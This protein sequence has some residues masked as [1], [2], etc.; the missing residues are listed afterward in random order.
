MKLT[1][2]IFAS[3][4]VLGT[5]CDRPDF[6]SQAKT[7]DVIDTDVDR[8]TPTGS[9]DEAGA[10]TG[11]E[12]DDG[13]RFENLNNAQGAPP[14]EDADEAPARDGDL[15]AIVEAS[16]NLGFETYRARAGQ[17]GPIAIGSYGLTRS[18]SVASL[19]A[20]EP[21]RTELEARVSNGLVGEQLHDAFNTLDSDL[22]TR[23][24]ASRIDLVTATWVP[25]SAPVEQAFVDDLARYYG[26]GVRRAEFESRPEDARI[27]INNFYRD[28]T[29]GELTDVVPVRTVDAT[30]NV[31]ITDGNLFRGTFED[32]FD[33]AYTAATDFVG[34]SGTRSVP[35]MLR[36]GS[37]LGTTLDG[38]RAIEL[39]FDSG[40]SLLLI[41]PEA[42]R[43]DEIESRFDQTLVDRILSNLVPTY[44]VLG[45]PRVTIADRVDV[46]QRAGELG[47]DGAF[48][49]DFSGVYADA[50]LSNIVQRTRLQLVEDGVNA[51]PVGLAPL[52]ESEAA[53][54]DVPSI[55]FSRPF[56]YLVRDNETGTVLFL[57]RYE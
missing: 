42:G 10:P 20:S 39:P 13:G 2:A 1:H 40:F 45:V 57:G 43:F 22:T 33:P 28:R 21:A 36:E 35:M 27:S 38:L 9:G 23:D 3:L 4:L 15:A 30:T 46:L 24:G 41:L 7:G 31:L 53:A 55:F 14:V 47:L 34:P 5:A 18:A 29:G 54:A 26:Q 37:V 32:A 51:D 11:D 56:L 19:G 50:E 48:N 52:D 17:P 6:G 12:S 49:S 8:E 44:L 25:Q 16:S